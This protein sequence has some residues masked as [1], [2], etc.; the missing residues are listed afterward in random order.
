MR[1]SSIRV[2]LASAFLLA[3]AGCASGGSSSPPSSTSSSA[4]PAAS[5]CTPGM[6]QTCNDNPEI[7]SLHGACRPD[8]TCECKGDFEKNE[9]TGRCQ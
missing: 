6:D 9:A 3:T 7:S 2:A 8:G 1:T 4:A 5:A